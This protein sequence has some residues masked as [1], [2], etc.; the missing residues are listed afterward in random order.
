MNLATNIM[1][2]FLSRAG[3]YKLKRIVDLNNV[4]MYMICTYNT[5]NLPCFSTRI[6]REQK[7]SKVVFLLS[8]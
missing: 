7:P 8:Y 1:Q 3:V 6:N 4:P 2:F 5:H